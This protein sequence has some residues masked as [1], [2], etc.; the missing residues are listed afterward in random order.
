M[1]SIHTHRSI[2]HV[3]TGVTNNKGSTQVALKKT[4]A[5]TIYTNACRIENGHIYVYTYLHIADRAVGSTAAHHKYGGSTTLS[6]QI[7]PNLQKVI[8]NVMHI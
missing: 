3:V 5:E 1:Y 2:R 4:D 6:E 8:M 7:W